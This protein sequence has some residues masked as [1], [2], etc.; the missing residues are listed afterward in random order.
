MVE[1]LQSLIVLF[2]FPTVLFMDSFWTGL[3]L[4]QKILRRKELISLCGS[5]RTSTQLTFELQPEHQP[6]I[7]KHLLFSVKKK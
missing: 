4:L 1:S 6:Y 2:L 5:S 7:I 3:A